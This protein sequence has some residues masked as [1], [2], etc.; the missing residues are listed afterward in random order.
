MAD[1]LTDIVT[2]TTE[3][4]L[5]L[6]NKPFQAFIN[7]SKKINQIANYPYDKER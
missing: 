6:R 4:N 1:T 5:E 2:K 7:E 3:Q